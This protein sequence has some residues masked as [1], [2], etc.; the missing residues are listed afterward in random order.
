MP[1]GSLGVALEKTKGKGGNGIVIRILKLSGNG[2]AMEAGIKVGDV[3]VEI[4]GLPLAGMDLRAVQNKLR[5]P[6]GAPVRIKGLRTGG[7]P[8]EVIVVRSSASAGSSLASM[9]EAGSAVGT[10][11]G[12]V[13]AEPTVSERAREAVKSAQALSDEIA[14]LRAANDASVAK[15]GDAAKL[16]TSALGGASAEAQ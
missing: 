14:R 10:S 3:L 11:T 7:G 12:H 8:F 9:S 6:S 15:L 16:Q 1:T 5:G 4:D 13:G 2:A